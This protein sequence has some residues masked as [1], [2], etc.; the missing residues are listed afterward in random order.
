M[1]RGLVASC[2]SCLSQAV[3]DLRRLQ[4]STRC[5]K[6][7]PLVLSVLL[8]TLS[9]PFLDPCSLSSGQPRS[10]PFSRVDLPPRTKSNN[11]RSLTDVELKLSTPMKPSF[12]SCG[13]SAVARRSARQQAGTTSRRRG[14]FCTR[15][16][17]VRRPPKRTQGGEGGKK[18][19]NPSGQR[20]CRRSSLAVVTAHTRVFHNNR[21]TLT[22]VE[23]KLSTPTKPSFSS[24]GRSTV[25]RR[26][27]R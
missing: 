5:F 8:F 19:R 20:C 27:A 3:S 24:C 22:D 1:P 16:D 9:F 26:S 23:P 18:L 10:S 15:P 13:R 6:S 7:P 4:A 21:R 25:A 14:A 11:R 12:S 17:V 2:Q